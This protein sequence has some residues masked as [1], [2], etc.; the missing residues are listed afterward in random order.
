MEALKKTLFII[1][2]ISVTGYTI[3][4]VYLQ[5][6]EPHSSVLDQYDDA[7]NN[8]IK[9]ATSLQELEK[10]YAEAHQTTKALERIDSIKAM[11][12]YKRS[13]LEQYRNESE[14]KAAILE[15][16][17]NSQEIYQIRFFWTIGL[18]LAILGF[19]VYKKI[20]LWLGIT[21]LITGFGEMV[22]W[23]S[24]VFFRSGVEYDRLLANKTIL[25]VAT[26]VLLIVAAFLT[27]SM[28]S[29]TKGD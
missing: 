15:W 11:E 5:W 24:P 28:K 9:K 13:Q 14:I 8:K 20:N 29:Q 19:V 23:T 27:D 22:Y 2:M 1:A 26:L 25:S 7:V 18:A 6:F 12:E 4:H 21:V 17:T 3:R 16:E 10:L